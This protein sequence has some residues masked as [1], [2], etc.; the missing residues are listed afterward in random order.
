MIF[1]PIIEP[2][3]VPDERP[4]GCTDEQP[5]ISV[6]CLGCARGMVCPDHLAIWQD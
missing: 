4:Q 6:N 2:Q 1:E 5:T 3:E